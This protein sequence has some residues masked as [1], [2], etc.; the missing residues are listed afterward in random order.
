L[1]RWVAPLNFNA[2]D[3]A[4]YRDTVQR[5]VREGAAT[6]LVWALRWDEI[7]DGTYDAEDE[8]D[9]GF[10]LWGAVTSYGQGTYSGRG[11]SDY[12]SGELTVEQVR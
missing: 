5:V 3:A 2:W 8:A 6:G 9:L 12:I 7:V 4:D 10:L 1:T 11:S